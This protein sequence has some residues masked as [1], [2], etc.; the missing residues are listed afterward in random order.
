MYIELR[1]WSSGYSADFARVANNIN[2]ARYQRDL[3][4][5]PCS[6]VSAERY[7][8]VCSD[9]DE[10]CSKAIFA[11]NSF[12]GFVG[13]SRKDDVSQKSA[14]LCY[15]LD[16]KYWGMGIMTGAVRLFTDYYFENHDV[17]RIYAIT[18][19]DNIGSCRVLEKAG[20]ELEG[21]MKKSAYKLGE[22]HDCSIYAAVR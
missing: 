11:D 1:D 17:V 18:F 14:E 2:I 15:W 20:Y 13:A 10:I 8:R 22:Y 21:V 7:I 9:S 16:E 12:V 3:F 5:H 19:S 6:Q 4:P